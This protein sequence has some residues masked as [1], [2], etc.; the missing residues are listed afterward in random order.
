MTF[1]QAEYSKQ[2]AKDNPDKVRATKAKSRAKHIEKRRQE[3]REWQKNNPEKKEENRKAWRERNPEK[4]RK[5]CAEAGAKWRNANPVK[6]RA[7]AAVRRAKVRR[8]FVEWANKEKIE[9]FYEQARK[10]TELTGV[11]HVVDH[12]HPLTSKYICGLHNEHNLQVISKEE[13]TRK[14]NRF[15]PYLFSQRQGRMFG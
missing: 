13:N 6:R 12:I 10:M 3:V 8:A 11:P 5:V 7:K 4:Y 1:N 15:V 2:W 14:H 9:A